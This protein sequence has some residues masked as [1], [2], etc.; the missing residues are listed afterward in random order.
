MRVRFFC[1]AETCRLSPPCT[2]R[3]THPARI[4][5]DCRTKNLA[6]PCCESEARL[7]G[8]GDWSL[9][10]PE[11]ILPAG[12]GVHAGNAEE[13]FPESPVFSGKHGEYVDGFYP[14]SC[15]MAEK[16]CRNTQT[17]ARRNVASESA[18]LIWR[19]KKAG[20]SSRCYGNTLRRSLG[21]FPAVGNGPRRTRRLR[22][23]PQHGTRPGHVPT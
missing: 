18:T 21:P 7:R 17:R 13:S 12:H 4:R 1:T 3:S 8:G 20:A 2:T 6:G 22:S 11:Q 19:R 14:C 23:K 5:D 10:T 15:R 16:F 9:S